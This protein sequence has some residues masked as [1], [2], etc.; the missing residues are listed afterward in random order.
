VVN[1][2]NCKE[3]EYKFI[4]KVIVKT[5]KKK[6]M[7]RTEHEVAGPG[8]HVADLE[9]RNLPHVRQQCFELGR[10]QRVRT[11]TTSRN[12]SYK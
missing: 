8:G 10:L 12:R 2:N 6:G 9:V 7:M 1:A 11:S 3:Y 5:K 4:W